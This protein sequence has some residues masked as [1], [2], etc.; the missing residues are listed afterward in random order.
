MTGCI[1]PLWKV[2]VWRSLGGVV[3][4]EYEKKPGRDDDFFSL[5]EAEIYSE[6]VAKRPDVI[7]VEIRAEDTVKSYTGP[8]LE[9][10]KVPWS[11]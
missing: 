2:A 11:P 6:Q 5:A 9:S 8:A 1:R 7:Q 10:L 3:A 4:W